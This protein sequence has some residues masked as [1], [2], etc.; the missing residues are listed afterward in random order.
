MRSPPESCVVSRPP[1]SSSG[2]RTIRRQDGVPLPLELVAAELRPVADRLAEPH[3]R[4]G[5][6]GAV[7]QLA[8]RGEHPRP[9]VAQPRRRRLEQQLAHRPPG[10]RADADVLRHVGEGADVDVALGRR[11]LAGEDA[12]QRRLAD[13][14]GAHQPDVLPGRDLERDLAEQLVAAR[15]GVREVGDGDVRHGSAPIGA[16]GVR[17]GFEPVALE[18]RGQAAQDLA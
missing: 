17:D 1:T 6:V 3:A 9:G 14:V 10:V 7:R 11:E 8:L 12:E 16:D 13:A 4:A 5:R 2:A 18:Q 15:V